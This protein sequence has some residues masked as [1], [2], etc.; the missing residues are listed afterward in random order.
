MPCWPRSTSPDVPGPPPKLPANRARN[1]TAELGVLV[2]PDAP[3]CDPPED[4]FGLTPMGRL[5]LGVTLGGAAE[6]LEKAADVAKRAEEAKQRADPRVADPRSPTA[7]PRAA[8]GGL[9]GD[10]ARPRRGRSRG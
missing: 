4:R 7:D 10:G 1:N 6:G 5:R 3:L 2:A 8:G 9:D